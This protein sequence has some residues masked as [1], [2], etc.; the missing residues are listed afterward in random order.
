MEAVDGCMAEILACVDEQPEWVALVTADHGNC[1]MMM[2]SEGNV[3]T[4]HTT[5]P[6]DFIVYDPQKGA[7]TLRTET[8]LGDVAPTVLGFMGLT[9]PVAMTGR[10]I[11]VRGSTVINEED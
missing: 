10:D 6:V 8:R 7:D 11:V 9:Q 5:E 3:H 2:D 1:E 4:A